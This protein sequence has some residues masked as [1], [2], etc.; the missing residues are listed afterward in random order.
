M[1]AFVND[2]KKVMTTILMCLHKDSDKKVVLPWH[3]FFYE[4]KWQAIK[5]ITKKVK[6]LP[7]I[8]HLSIYNWCVHKILPIKTCMHRYLQG[9]ED[10]LTQLNKKLILMM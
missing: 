2:T 10:K 7:N 6:L 3:F 4:K 5:S 1:H 8:F 9:L